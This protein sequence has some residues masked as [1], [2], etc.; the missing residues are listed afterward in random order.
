MKDRVLNNSQET[1][2][3]SCIYG[4]KHFRHFEGLV[5]HMKNC[6]GTVP[7]RSTLNRAVELSLKCVYTRNDILLYST[8]EAS[9][10]YKHCNL[11]T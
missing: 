6:S 4:G 5:S 2:L 9:P 1:E 3:H 11:I 7:I 10:I 8:D